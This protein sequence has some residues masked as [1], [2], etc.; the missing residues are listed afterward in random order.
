MA[1]RTFDVT[2][3]FGGYE[4]TFSNLEAG[5]SLPKVEPLSD[6]VIRY[7]EM[8]VDGEPMPL[9]KSTLQLTF[10]DP[11]GRL[12]DQVEARQLEARL[13]GP[14]VD[15]RG[16]LTPRRALR[17]LNWKTKP[18]NLDLAFYD[19]IADL[20]TDAQSI[21]AGDIDQRAD[22]SRSGDYG[23]ALAFA[24]NITEDG[25]GASADSPGAALATNVE[26]D[27]DDNET[28]GQQGLDT[29]LAAADYEAESLEDDIKHICATLQCRAFRTLK[30]GRFTVVPA[31]Q[32]VGTLSGTRYYFAES[33]VDPRR[34]VFGSLTVET[35][36]ET[37]ELDEKRFETFDDDKS[38]F[39]F[40]PFENAGAVEYE[41]GSEYNLVRNPEFDV[42]VGED[43][44]SFPHWTTSPDVDQV[45]GSETQASS[46]DAPDAEG[47]AL[48]SDSGSTETAEQQI[49]EVAP[50]GTTS[51]GLPSGAVLFFDAFKMGSPS[52]TPSLTVTLRLVPDDGSS[53]VTSTVTDPFGPDQTVQISFD[54]AGTLYVEA[55]GIEAAWF[56]PELRFLEGGKKIAETLIYRNPD[57]SDRWEAETAGAARILRS[58]NVEYWPPVTYRNTRFSV[59]RTLPWAFNA[60]DRLRR[61]PIDGTAVRTRVL[62]MHGPETRIVL[63]HP[64]T[65]EELTFYGGLGRLINVTRGDTELADVQLPTP[66][67]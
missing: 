19:G 56:S 45:S 53:D 34:Q 20:K 66:I 3:R 28:Y 2:G 37:I 58:A 26:M 49:G 57:S 36:P 55:D 62:G 13:T 35:E 4:L 54:K 11:R 27:N 25:L 24:G 32:P 64:V 6:V 10:F 48:G 43:D 52:Q 46:E 61:R 16:R 38:S 29:V 5:A 23:R 22:F 30:D 17:P 15:W 59:S 33:D 67:A 1:A 8:S 7:G 51:G 50:A 44:A 39:G 31:A 60:T 9:L 63:V 18:G 40:H 12:A 21:L 41:V 42:D 47:M 14:G 65:G